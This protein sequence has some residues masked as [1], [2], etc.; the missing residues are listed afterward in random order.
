MLDSG[1]WNEK[2]QRYWIEAF[3]NCHKLSQPV[4]CQHFTRHFMN[5]SKYYVILAKSLSWKELKC[6]VYS[7]NAEYPLWARER[8]RSK[9]SLMRR[10]PSPQEQFLTQAALLMSKSKFLTGK[11]SKIGFFCLNICS[12]SLTFPKIN[13][14]WDIF[15]ALSN[16][17]QSQS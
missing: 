9:S 10:R 12:L 11:K 15:S 13:L 7:K 2:S 5:K 6:N 16:I 8:E 14:R 4:C 3:S 1:I 17:K